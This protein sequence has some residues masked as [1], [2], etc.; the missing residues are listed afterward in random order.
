[1]QR[2]PLHQGLPTKEEGN[3]LEEAYYT[4]LGGPFQGGGY[5]ATAPGYYQR[6]NANHSFQERR[7][8]MEDTLSLLISTDIA[9]I[10]RKR[11]KPDKHGHG[12]GRARKEPGE[13]YQKSRMLILE[14]KLAMEELMDPTSLFLDK[15]ELVE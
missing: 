8:S 12:N 11:S 7:Q 4:Q 5:R 3:T 2:T 10:T 1:M 15:L 13:S 6:N 9:K 14:D